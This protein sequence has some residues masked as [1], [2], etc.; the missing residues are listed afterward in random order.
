[1]SGVQRREP[2]T[3]ENVTQVTAAIGTGDLNPST[4]GVDRLRY[5]SI[6]CLVEG[7]PAATR[8]ELRDAFVQRG[9]TPATNERPGLRKMLE[10]TGE[11][12]LGPLVNKYALLFG[13]QLIQFDAIQKCAPFI[14]FIYSI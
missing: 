14:P 2:L 6:D 4:I 13:S 1:M 10:L 9:I 8:V 12:T 3:P 7:R 5:G 11:R